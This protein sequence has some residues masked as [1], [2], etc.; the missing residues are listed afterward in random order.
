MKQKFVKTSN[1]LRLDAALS[2]VKKRGASEACIIVVDGE[3]GLGKTTSL[4]R[5]AVQQQAIYLRAKKEFRP[6]W[7]LNE[8]L[9]ELRQDPPHAFEKKFEL[10]LKTLV[11]RQAAAIHAERTFA[12]IIDEADHI[13]S[14]ARIMETIRDLSDMIELPTI[15]V[16]MGKIRHN[17]TRFP[18]IT[19]RVSQYVKFE[20]ATKQDVRQ[21]FE[22]KCEVEVADD[23]ITYT[24]KVTGGMNREI[25]EAMAVIER[26][27]K[28][29]PPA[30]GGLTLRDM[31]GQHIVNDR[32]TGQAI[33]VPEVV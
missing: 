24:H 32:L 21:F 33:N 2:A 5:F 12:L 4:A 9:K 15:L 23:L 29:T 11:Q 31:A 20:T 28:R 13:S 7:F 6:A 22:D 8:L 10:A 17:L 18:Q 19:S 14:N 30:A 25:I 27:G 16:G 1:V 3:P 26:F